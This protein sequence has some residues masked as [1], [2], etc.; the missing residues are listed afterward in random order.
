MVNSSELTKLY[1]SILYPFGIHIEILWSSRDWKVILTYFLSDSS[2]VKDDVSGISMS[3][4]ELVD[5][6]QFMNV[7]GSG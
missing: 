5:P 7:N 1:K 3:L 2:L 6:E 4:P